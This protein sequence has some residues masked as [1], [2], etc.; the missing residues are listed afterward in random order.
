MYG[1]TVS[2]VVKEEKSSVIAVGRVMTCVLGLVVDREQEIRNFVPKKHY[3]ITASF[4]SG[5]S[6]L[7]YKGKWQPQKKDKDDEENTLK[8]KEAEE[9]IERL[10]GKVAQIKKVDIKKERAAAP[11]F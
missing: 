5:K 4:L 9:V 1:R 11:S 2:N 10:K 3:G 6:N 8:K 7:E